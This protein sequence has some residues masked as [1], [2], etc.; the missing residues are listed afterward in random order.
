MNCEYE[1]SYN[2]DAF[3]IHCAQ[4]G[5]PDMVFKPHE[6]GLHVLDI[7]DV[8]IANGVNFKK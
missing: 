6:S 2:G 8:A 5:Y 4:H 7:D 1:V 3:I